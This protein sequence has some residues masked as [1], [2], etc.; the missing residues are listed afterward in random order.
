MLELLK[1]ESNLT[2]TE[3]GAVT[4]K[5][6]HSHCLDLFATI[7]AIRFASDEEIITRFGRAYAEDADMA[8]KILFFGRDVRGGLG[9]RRVFRTIIKHLAN[10]QPVS[11]IRN[12]PYIAEYGRYDDLLCLLD[13][14]CADATMAEIRQQLEKDMASLEKGGQVSLLGKWL[15]S[16]NA[17]GKETVKLAK[18]I[19]RGLKISDADYRKMLSALRRQIKIIE[20]NLRQK[21]YSFDYEKQPSKAMLKYRKAFLRNDEIRYTDFLSRVAKGEA[22]L[23]TGTVMPYDIVGKIVDDLNWSEQ[24][25]DAPQRKALDITW[26][27]LEDFATGENAIVV[28]DGSGSMYSGSSP[29][30]VDVAVS[31]GIYFAERNT[32][33]FKNHFITFS[34]TPQLVEIKG[35]D[36]YEKAWY[37]MTYNEVADTNLQAVFSLILNTAVKNKVPQDQLPQKLYI[38]SDMEFN[39]CVQDRS[40]TNFEMAKA[41]FARFGYKLP[42][43]VFWNVASRN[44][45]QPVT[46]NENGV[47]LVSGASPRVFSMLSSDD[48]SPYTFM[49]EVIGSERYEKI[50]A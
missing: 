25:M 33:R 10:T 2:Y 34:H 42:Q 37:C 49:M 5:S 29:R 41:E 15:P 26:N 39:W 47:A 22:V 1:K 23:K 32:G 30:P 40:A 18:Q 16:V 48:F 12:L 31:L 11:V 45:Q 8:M 50:V 19:A 38:I 21:D 9:E 46:Q 36:I 13:T 17:S 24:R 20:N 7:G 44:R 6:T 3:N 4:Y 27:A 35:N 43:V 14:A 28:V